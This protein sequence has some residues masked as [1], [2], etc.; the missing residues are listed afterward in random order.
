L[1]QYFFTENKHLF[2]N[3]LIVLN[4]KDG[5]N[6]YY[7]TAEIIIKYLAEKQPELHKV[8]SRAVND[9][10]EFLP[11]QAI[12]AIAHDLIIHPCSSN[13]FFENPLKE[14]IKQEGKLL[15]SLQKLY[16]GQASLANLKE[17]LKIYLEEAYQCIRTKQPM[18][19][20]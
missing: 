6:E 10:T 11:L 20:K 16:L 18:A 3:F 19:G 14:V 4:G 12:A 13:F 7:N 1:S 8:F 2:L 9:T 17:G 15:Q 5:Y